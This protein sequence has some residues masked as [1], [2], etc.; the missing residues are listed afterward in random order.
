MMA[1]CM[2][3][4]PLTCNRGWTHIC[5]HGVAQL[6]PDALHAQHCCSSM[7]MPAVHCSTH[8]SPITPCTTSAANCS[9]LFRL[10]WSNMGTWTNRGGVRGDEAATAAAVAAFVVWRCGLLA[11]AQNPVLCTLRFRGVTTQQP[12]R[13]PHNLEALSQHSSPS[14]DTPA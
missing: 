5:V 14:P 10:S 12:N 8:L 11:T 6:S 13:Q 3:P 9:W 4:D 2:L 7:S 1:G